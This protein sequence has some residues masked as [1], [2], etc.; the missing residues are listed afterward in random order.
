[1][2]ASKVIVVPIKGKTIGNVRLN[3]KNILKVEHFNSF[4]PMLDWVPK[5]IAI[6]QNFQSHNGKYNKH[7]QPRKETAYQ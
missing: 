7:T 2:C 6:V 3:R 4:F 5:E 1:L